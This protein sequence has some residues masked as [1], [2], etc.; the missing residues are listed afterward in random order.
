MMVLP[1][2]KKKMHPK[3]V[4]CLP[5]RTRRCA[6]VVERAALEMRCTRKG[7]GGSNPSI[8][9]AEK[10]NPLQINYLQR[11]LFLGYN[12]GYSLGRFCG[13][14]SQLR[15]RPILPTCNPAFIGA[16]TRVP[17]FER[18]RFAAMGT[19]AGFIRRNVHR[20]TFTV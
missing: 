7:T 18:K 1:K 8:S 9:A 13:F 15:P 16:I 14:L 4:K 12:G 3:K 2:G 11:V 17:M 10:I 5:L 6:R 19:K 20:I